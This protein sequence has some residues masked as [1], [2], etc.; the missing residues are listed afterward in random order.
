MRVIGYDLVDENVACLKN[1]GLD[2]VIDQQPITQGYLA[3]QSLYKHLI[4]KA[5]VPINQY[6]PL[7]L[8]TKENLMYCDY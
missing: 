8:L 6:L 5:Q 7:D 2:F 1:G 3:V 4:L